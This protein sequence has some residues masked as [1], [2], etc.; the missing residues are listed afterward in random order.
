[1]SFFKS[2]SSSNSSLAWTLRSSSGG[3]LLRLHFLGL[4][5]VFSW[6]D[7]E[8]EKSDLSAVRFDLFS[9]GGLSLRGSNLS[10]MFLSVFSKY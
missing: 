3:L 5:I 2:S 7:A 10:A 8:S 9:P 1:M 4:L 6:S